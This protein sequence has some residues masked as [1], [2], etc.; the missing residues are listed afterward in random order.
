MYRRWLDPFEELRRMQEWMNRIAGEFEP[1]GAERLLP[2][3]AGE[4]IMETA[5]PSVDVQ[6]TEDRIL[7]TADVPGVEKEDITVSVRGDLLEITAEKSKEE[8]ET[9]EG[10]V[11][12]ERG[13]SR[14]YRR[15]PLPTEVDPNKVDATL[16]D[17]VLRVEMVKTALPE[18]KKI[19][20][21]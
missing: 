1:I 18:V 13:Y 7:V 20:V 17:G 4:E 15:M 2:T 10:Y 11:R 14:F 16:K 6:D 12:R 19:E 3:R 9:G 5:T 21:K 8:E